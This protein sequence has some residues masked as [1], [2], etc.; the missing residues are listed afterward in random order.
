VNDRIVLPLGSTEQHAYLSLATD[1]ILAERV[2][3]EAAEPT[4]V[5]VPPVLAYR[6][7]PLK[8]GK[9]QSGSQSRG[10]PEAQ[11]PGWPG[12]RRVPRVRYKCINLNSA[13]AQYRARAGQWGPTCL[14]V[15]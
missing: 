10:W 14:L 4:G 11:T 6:L 3:V 5:P 2:A 12:R 1:S 15:S 7:T 9:S 8:D 13:R